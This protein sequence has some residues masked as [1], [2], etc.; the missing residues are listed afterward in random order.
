[1]SNIIAPVAPLLK[2]FT[3]DIAR[4]AVKGISHGRMIDAD[5]VKQFYVKETDQRLENVLKQFIDAILKYLTD[6]N[7]LECEEG[8]D[9]KCDEEQDDDML[10]RAIEMSLECNSSCKG[11]KLSDLDLD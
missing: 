10:K 2:L 11:S 8:D 5:G 9:G 6:E 7:I 1:M 3:R 4:T